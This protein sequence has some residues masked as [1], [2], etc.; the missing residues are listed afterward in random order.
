MLAAFFLAGN[1]WQTRAQVGELERA[2]YIAGAAREVSFA[3]SDA[4]A[5]ARVMFDPAKNKFF[6]SVGD[7]PGDAKRVKC[8]LIG[9]EGG[10]RF[11]GDFDAS[12]GHASWWVLDAGGP[13]QDYEMFA[14]TDDRESNLVQVSLQH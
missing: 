11:L 8:W 6:V 7:L 3:R 2:V 1:W 5:W 10:A 9:P 12:G 4:G 14:I 13:L